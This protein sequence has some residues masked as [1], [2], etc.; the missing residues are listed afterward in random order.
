MLADQLASGAH[1]GVAVAVRYRGE[2]VVDVWGGAFEE[3]SMAISFSTTKGPA[4]IALHMVLERAGLGYDT[5]VADV[6]PEFARN[7]KETVTIRHCLCHEAGIPQIREQVA[8]VTDM[9]DWDAMVAMT[10]DLTPLWQPG[11]ANG[12][13]ALNY[14]WLV[15]ELVRRIDGRT[16]S[17][18]LAEEVAGPLELD[19]FYIGT[20]ESEHHR[21][22]P[23]FHDYP[24]DVV[25]SFEAMIEQN[26]Y[27]WNALSPAGDMNTFLN[28]PAGMSTCGPAFTGAFTARSLA[29]LYS[30]MERGGSLAGTRLLK[31]DTIATATTVQNKRPDLVMVLPIY[32]RLGFMGGGSILSPAG[33]NRE[34]Y[35]HS[36]WG[37]SIAMADPK[38]KIA[39]AVVLDRLELDFLGGD[40][41]RSVIHAAVAAAES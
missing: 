29:T 30:A 17:Q 4:A 37:G 36:G 22:V 1:H 12:Y 34:A 38:A 41:T 8:D 31:E 20:P 21:I 9:A 5:P 3:D 27:A 39:V 40:R 23:V 33:P 19:G 35:G 6:W 11:T 28:S 14:G 32:W 13:H 7:G 10:E 18:F 24:Q 25:D 16:I 15:G 2:P 26:P